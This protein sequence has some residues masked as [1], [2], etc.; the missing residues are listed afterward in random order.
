MVN[1]INFEQINTS[2]IFD[3]NSVYRNND[4][5]EDN[6]MTGHPQSFIDN[7]CSYMAPC[8]VSSHVTDRKESL[9]NDLSFFSLNVRGLTAH[10][11]Q[12]NHLLCEIGGSTN[13][14]FDLIG[15]SEI[16]TVPDNVSLKLQG[17]HPLEIKT[18]PDGG[19]GGVG[20][21]IKENLQYL[22]RDDL[23]VFIPHV[24]ETYFVE[25]YMK[26]NKNIIVGIVYRPNTE[27]LADI[28]LFINSITDIIQN[29]NSSHKQFVIMGD[30][31]INLLNYNTNRNTTHFVDTI[32]SEGTLPLITKPTRI[33]DHSATLIDHIHTNIIGKNILSGIILTDI[34][35]HPGTFY[36]FR[37][38]ETKCKPQ[39][40]FIKSY[41]TQNIV[42]FKEM[43]LS[44]DFSD[45]MSSN[46]AEIALEQFLN[47]YK[48]L[49]DAAFPIKKINIKSRNIKRSPWMTNGLLTS[50]I[51]K[52]KLFRKKLKNPSELNVNT[53]KTY[54]TTFNK[55]CRL[56][57]KNYYENILFEHRMNMKQTWKILN[58]I[59]CKSKSNK[60]LPSSF[61]INGQLNFDSRDIANGLNDFFVSIGKNISDQIATDASNPSEYLEDKNIPNFFLA[62]IVTHD[63]IKIAKSLKSKTNQGHDKISTKLMKQTI[64][65]IAEPLEHIFNLSLSTGIVPTSSKIARIILVYKS[66]DQSL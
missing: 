45:V 10:W 62:P 37:R 51:H 65:E 13:F 15:L 9:Q 53:Y 61:R 19:K 48:S 50:S 22:P 52:N 35:D 40:K 7:I 21:Y 29:L 14:E 47:I 43:L 39:Y 12:L 36:V 18:R 34:S 66:G 8:D 60:S 44:A 20:L 16:F 4:F 6:D 42:T 30:F 17:Y 38:M 3:F 5:N 41:N 58:D 24:I 54:C 2:D 64:E 26:S 11:D 49:S 46:S 55:L 32:I 56:M 33:T 57:K 27:P 31:N 1:N 28:D 25:I 63:I 59:I 23:T